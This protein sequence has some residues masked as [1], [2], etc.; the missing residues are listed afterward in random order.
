[1]GPDKMSKSNM[2]YWW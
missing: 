2:C 1:M